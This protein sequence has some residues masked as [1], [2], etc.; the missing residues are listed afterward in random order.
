MHPAQPNTSCCLPT[1]FCD[2]GSTRFPKAFYTAEA[3]VPLH[4]PHLLRSEKDRIT[5]REPIEPVF[6]NVLTAESIKGSLWRH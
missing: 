5:K 4:K 1:W 3:G 6:F 2:C